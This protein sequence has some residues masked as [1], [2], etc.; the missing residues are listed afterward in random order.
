MSDFWDAARIVNRDALSSYLL[1]NGGREI[2]VEDDNEFILF[3]PWVPGFLG[4]PI[5]TV[6]LV[7]RAQAG[8]VAGENQALRDL[9]V[10]LREDGWPGERALDTLVS[11]VT[12]EFKAIQNLFELKTF[13]EIVSE[14][15]PRVTVE[16][17]TARGGTFF[18]LCQVSAEDARLVSV[19][20]P[21]GQFGGGYSSFDT[22]VFRSFAGPRQR[23]YFIRQ[24]SLERE[25]VNRLREYLNGAEIDLLFID[26]NHNYG[27]VKSDFELY[28]P[29]VRRG[30][31]VAFHDINVKPATHGPGMEVGFF[32]DE[33]AANRDHRVISDPN[34]AYATVG[35]TGPRKQPIA[36]GI[37]VLEV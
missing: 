15:R 5:E 32:W 17:G 30:G 2:D 9:E 1:R 13:L 12:K 23:T 35:L 20:L 25:S 24:S 34:G 6:A 14:A 11:R 7:R 3:N 21:G 4:I 28:G 31:L 29:L 36:W 26:G 22:S 27:A 19:D 37:G 10:E 18:C 16:I 8:N 33:L